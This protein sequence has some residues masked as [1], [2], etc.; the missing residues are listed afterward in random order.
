MSAWDDLGDLTTYATG[1]RYVF[2]AGA[3]SEDPTWA[4]AERALVVAGRIMAAVRTHL[5]EPR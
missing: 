4:E 2:D 3:K 5:G 1:P